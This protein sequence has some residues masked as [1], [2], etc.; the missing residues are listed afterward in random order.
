MSSNND[1][2]ATSVQIANFGV[3]D[4]IPVT[5]THSPAPVLPKGVRAYGGYLGRCSFA[6][7]LPAFAEDIIILQLDY[8]SRVAA[9]LEQT[10]IFETVPGDLV[11]LPRGHPVQFV[12]RT[13]DRSLNLVVALPPHMLEE[14]ASSDFGAAPAHVELRPFM[15][16]QRDPLLHCIGW[17]VHQQLQAGLSDQ[18]YMESL[19]TTMAFHLVRTYST[20]KPRGRRDK[21]LPAATVRRVCDYVEANLQNALTLEELGVVAGYS[22][23]HLARLFRSTIGQTLHDYV[24]TQRLKRA[25]VLLVTTDLTLQEIAET[26]GFHHQSHLSNQFRQFYGC[27]PSSIRR[28]PGRS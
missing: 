7:H 25:K 17:A 15:A 27:T 28:A 2:S 24:V 1:P 5:P 12:N 16:K 14:T 6:V 22:P 21:A 23:Y 4:K 13:P 10:H 9:T 20:K 3:Y 18:L 11:V 19:M 26:V 8:G